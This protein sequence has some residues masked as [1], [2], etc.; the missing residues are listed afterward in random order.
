ME[1]K[2]IASF[3]EDQDI[4]D[5]Y[6]AV[7]EG[8]VAILPR[9]F[10]GKGE[11]FQHRLKLC[12]RYVVLQKLNMEPEDIL[13]RIKRPFLRKYKLD[14]VVYQLQSKGLQELLIDVFPEIGHKNIINVKLPEIG[15]TDEEII[16]IYDAAIEGKLAHFPKGFW[17]NHEE[18]VMHRLKLSLRYVVL[19]KLK[20]H[21]QDILLEVTSLFLSKY[22]LDYVVYQLQS[23][24]LQELLIDVF[25]EIEFENKA[26]INLYNAAIEGKLT[27]FPRG[28]WGN[29]EEEVQHRLKLCLRYL[30][31]EK[32][33]IKPENILLRVQQPFLIKYKLHQA[34]YK[35]QSKGLQE[36][37]IDVFPEIGHKNIISVKLPENGYTDEVIINI[38]DAAIE[39]KLAQLPN[40]FWGKNEEEVQHRLQLCLRYLV[41][42]KLKIKPHEIL[43]RVQKPFLVK[44]K[45]DYVVYQRQFK[46]LREL[47]MN[48]FPEIEFE[49]KDI[50]EV[51]DAAIEGESAQLPR[52]FWGKHEE[53]VLHRL[54]L[55]LRYL[56]LE[57]LKIKP[58]EILLRVQKPF[59]VKYKL[60]YVVYQRLS[61]RLQALLSDIFPEIEYTDEDIINR[62]DAVIEGRLDRFPHGFWGKEEEEVQHRLKLCLRHV[63][64]QKLN[65]EPEDILLRVKR[66]FLRKYKLDYVVYQLQSKGLQELLIDVFPEIG[67]KSIINVKLPEIG[68]TDEEIINMY[69]AVIDG[70]LAQLPHGFWGNNEEDVMHRLKL[71]LRYVVLQKL[72][73][74]PQEIFLKVTRPFLIKYKLYYAY[75]RQ[76][77]GL[78][79][80]LLEVFPEIEYK[81]EAIIN[82][83]DAAIEGKLAQLP[84]G[85]W[86]NSE[87]EVQHRLKLCLRYVVLQKLNIEPQ[88]ILLEVTT[89]FLMKYKLFHCVY[90]RQTKGLDELLKEAF[91]EI[92]KRK[93]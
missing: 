67:H 18:E 8:K 63:V 28:F 6:D 57:K 40:G 62:Y 16:N 2:G 1:T 86:G 36:L 44:Y 74:K 70:K 84:N 17:G 56:V 69:D 91:P 82:I 68:S 37:L 13:L 76:S 71:S 47:L 11:V 42:E 90:E 34:V 92:D 3:K 59:L 58:H 21:P 78:Q 10:W 60:D 88:E 38:Y 75:K 9:N 5:I 15:S 32:L 93:G 49:D 41:L 85:F 27:R 61:K 87:K 31:L 52:G 26:I 45:L 65:M 89:S 81:D 7:I 77:K 66:P 51:F 43:L 54:Q 20:I 46:G 64:L 19:Q 35:R 23:K 30:V 29:H 48:I 33:K 55:C 22:K 79:E 83:Y 39:G 80:L 4:I 53:E 24:G 73:M 72:K 14:Y 12:F 25:P 50:I